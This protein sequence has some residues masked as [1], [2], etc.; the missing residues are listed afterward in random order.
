VKLHTCHGVNYE[1]GQK[2]TLIR[3]CDLRQ[4]V[5]DTLLVC[6]VENLSEEAGKL[7]RQAIERA[8]DSTQDYTDMEVPVET[9]E[10]STSG[11]EGLL[12]VGKTAKP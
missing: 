12:K 11:L 4:E 7:V 9:Q 6:V 2:Q 1:R 10:I 8:R 3:V 5:I